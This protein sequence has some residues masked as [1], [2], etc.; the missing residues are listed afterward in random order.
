MPDPQRPGN[1]KAKVTAMFAKIAV[2]GGMVRET[3]EWCRMEITRLKIDL[4]TGG[5]NIGKD[6]REVI[7]K[8][9]TG[10]AAL[11]PPVCIQL[12]QR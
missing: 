10:Q 5:G 12:V 2:Q 9:Q 3:A 11:F 7:A 8:R 4:F 1:A 6:V